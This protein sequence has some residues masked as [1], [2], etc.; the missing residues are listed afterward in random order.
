VIRFENFIPQTAFISPKDQ[1]DI[2]RGI[3]SGVN[4]II[5]SGVK[6]AEHV[7]ELKQF[8]LA[9]KGRDVRI[10]V[11]IQTAEAIEHLEEILKICDGVTF[12]AGGFENDTKKA[13]EDKIITLSKNRA[14]PVIIHVELD[15][16]KAS[17]QDLNTT[18]AWY[19][20]RCVDSFLLD[21]ETATGDDPLAAINGLF[22]GMSKGKVPDTW[23]GQ[24]EHMYHKDEHE[25]VDYLAASA[26]RMTRELYV[27]AIICF[28]ESGYLAAKLSSLKAD[29]PVIAFTKQDDTYRFINLLWGI[30]GYKISPS[31]S[32]MD[33]KRTGKEMIRMNFKGNISL[34]DKIVI[35]QANELLKSPHIAHEDEHLA[36][37]GIEIYKFKDI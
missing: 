17:K 9:H 30:R 27:K 6:K 24:I 29:I 10:I 15:A 28:T 3:Q 7:Q 13:L 5:A 32:Y 34:D 16:L 1:K 36:I 4:S 2:I 8:L 21:T 18:L 26:L 20:E 25:I 22:D 11:K 31:S 23:T 14:K 12:T 35:V 37:N 19:L 33:L